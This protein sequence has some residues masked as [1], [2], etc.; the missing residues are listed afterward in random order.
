M[1]HIQTV[2]GETFGLLTRLMQD[3]ALGD[4]D[5]VGGTA[6]ALYLGHRISIDLDLFSPKP[7]D[8]EEL[9]RYLAEKYHFEFEFI[10]KHTLMGYVDDVKVDFI[11]HAYPPLDEKHITD[12]GIRL[13]SMRDI[14]AMKLAAIAGNGTRLKD[15][16]DIAYLSTRMPLYEMLNC[17][18]R[19]FTDTTAMSALRSLTYFADIDHSVPIQ[20]M[21][22]AY[23]W[24]NIERRLLEMTDNPSLIFATSPL[25]EE[26]QTQKRGIRR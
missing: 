8:A 14:A 5:L 23:K 19:K 1:L 15:F 3:S 7:F 25:V 16:I 11:T 9:R 2:K 18:E 4:F 20:M 6:L 17:Y 26:V 22:E 21:E 13:I 10:G 24:A 12:E